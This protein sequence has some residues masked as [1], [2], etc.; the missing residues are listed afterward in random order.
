MANNDE[1][2]LKSLMEINRDIGVIKGIQSSMKVQMS[3][4]DKSM[5]SLEV[6]YPISGMQAPAIQFNKN[7]IVACIGGI[8]ALLGVGI[9]I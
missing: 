2:I 5:E 7:Q 3:A 8:L 1:L 6:S 9:S 4:L